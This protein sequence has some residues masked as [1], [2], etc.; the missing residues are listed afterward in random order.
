MI[1]LVWASAFCWNLLMAGLLARRTAPSSDVSAN[2][3]KPLTECGCFC[4][5][6]LLRP[7]PH[8][9]TILSQSET[10]RE[11][12]RIAG[13][14]ACGGEPDAPHHCIA[15]RRTDHACRRLSLRAK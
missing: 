14:A 13:T 5:S 7:V 4:G 15:V 9:V 1:C 11:R 12:R 10:K 6:P 2:R 3:A 8:N